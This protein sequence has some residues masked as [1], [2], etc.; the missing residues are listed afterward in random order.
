MARLTID[1]K[2]AVN[3]ISI[4]EST[5]ATLICIFVPLNRYGCWKI[6]SKYFGT[7]FVKRPY[8]RLGIVF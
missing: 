2:F 4:E 1:E 8:T 3:A 5:S 7:R 6:E